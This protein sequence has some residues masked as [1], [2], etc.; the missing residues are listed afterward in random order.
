VAGSP[1]IDLEKLHDAIQ[2][3]TQ[4]TLTCQS[5]VELIGE[6]NRGNKC[7]EEIT[8]KTY[9]KVEKTPE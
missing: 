2:T 8:F 1:I 9:D 7:D 6:V 4:C 5:P 3:I